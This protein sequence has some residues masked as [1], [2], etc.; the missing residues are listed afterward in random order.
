MGRGGRRQQRPLPRVSKIGRDGGGNAASPFVFRAKERR[1]RPDGLLFAFRPQGRK[2][3]TGKGALMPPS[4]RF[5]GGKDRVMGRGPLCP[6]P[7]VSRTGGRGGGRSAPS[8]AF[9]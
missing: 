1:R 6:L 8:P 4:S 5:S 7:L 3:R 2:G 9:R